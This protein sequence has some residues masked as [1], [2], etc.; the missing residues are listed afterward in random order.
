MQRE[1]SEK[2]RG[3]GFSPPAN[4]EVAAEFSARRALYQQV[5]RRMCFEGELVA[6]TPLVAVHHSFYEAAKETFLG[7]FETQKTVTLAEFRT[8]LGVSRKIAQMYLD[9]FDKQKLSKL[10]GEARVLLA[11]T[12]KA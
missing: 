5:F 9:Y 4:E 8:E 10:M 11:R 1:L 3:Y 7:M 12:E 2:Y 6:L